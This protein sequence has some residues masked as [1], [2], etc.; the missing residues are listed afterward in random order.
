MTRELGFNANGNI[1]HRYPGEPTRAERGV[2]DAAK[3]G[4]SDRVDMDAED[5]ERLWSA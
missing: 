3:V 5:F 1:V 4:A 2:F